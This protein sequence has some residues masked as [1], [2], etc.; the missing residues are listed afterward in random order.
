MEAQSFPND[1]AERQPLSVVLT[2]LLAGNNPAKGRPW[3]VV[4]VCEKV[5]E[6]SSG[7]V[8]LSP[9]YLYALKSGVRD[10]PG[11]A[12]LLALADVFEVSPGYLLEGKNNP[13]PG[14]GRRALEKALADERITK[15]VGRLAELSDGEKERALRVLNAFVQEDQEER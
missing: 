6:V 11:P 7:R 9:K 3:R 1:P 2:R 12:I 8:T 14:S 4:E 15:I 10:N 5:E 13:A